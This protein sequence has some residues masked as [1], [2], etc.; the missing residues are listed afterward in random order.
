MRFAH[1][2]LSI[3][4]L[5]RDSR[6]RKTPLC[7]NFSLCLSRA[8]LGKMIVF[9][10]KKAPKKAFLFY[11]AFRKRLIGPIEVRIVVRGDV[12]TLP[13]L[14]CAAAS[15]CSREAAPVE[16]SRARRVEEQALAAAHEHQPAS[17]DNRFRFDPC[18]KRLL[19]ELFPY[20][21]P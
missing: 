3:A 6:C 8:C 21:R 19:S 12:E 5:T 16:P 1:R 10:M 20:V 4:T 13:L 7:L 17:D 15:T 2:R 9:S 11:R 14:L 18:R